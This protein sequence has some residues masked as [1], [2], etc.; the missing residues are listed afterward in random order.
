MR[1]LILIAMLAACG[2]KTSTPE[3]P[4]KPLGAGEWQAMSKS[5]RVHFMKHVMLP[6][7]KP[8]FQGFDATRFADF[9][10]KTCHGSGAERGTFQMPN[11]D[12]PKLS[13]DQVAHPDPDDAAI[14]EFMKTKV[15][16]TVAQT[17]GIPE[18]TPSAP[19]GFGCFDCHTQP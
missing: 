11:P 18:W 13:T 5:E 19:D 9:D 1:R 7:M 4:P 10:C 16:P 17:L 14:T 3:A 8:L 15:R 2:P 6:T 12:L